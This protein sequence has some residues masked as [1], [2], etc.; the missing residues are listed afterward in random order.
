MFRLCLHGACLKNKGSIERCPWA[1][2]WLLGV[3]T[4]HIT[5][6]AWNAKSKCMEQTMRLF[7]KL[8]NCLSVSLAMLVKILRAF[9]VETFASVWFL[10]CSLDSEQHLPNAFEVLH[11]VALP[12]AAKRIQSE[13][14]SHL[15]YHSSL[16]RSPPVFLYLAPV[17]CSVYTADFPAAH[18][19]SCY[20][21]TL[22]I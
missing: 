8:L 19:V 13:I 22:S 12:T 1:F 3:S 20:S 18:M 6:L 16:L 11:Q 14:I 7:F 2:L 10:L 9:L 4:S 5:F 15:S 21:I 17:G